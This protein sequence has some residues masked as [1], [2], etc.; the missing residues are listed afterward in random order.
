MGGGR[1]CEPCESRS[2]GRAVAPPGS[3][4]PRN[5]NQPTAPCEADDPQVR[6]VGQIG[7]EQR[8]LCGMALG[9]A[10]LRQHVVDDVKTARPQQRQRLIQELYLPGMASA[11]IRSYDAPACWCRKPAASAV[12]ISSRGSAPRMSRATACDPGS[13]STL[14]S[15][16]SRSMPSSNHA[17]ESPVPVPSSSRRPPGLLAASTRSIAPVLGSDGIGNAN[18]SVRPRTAGSAAGGFR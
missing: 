16:A 13:I 10:G 8:N 17:V 1:W 6:P 7:N 3:V 15:V 11:N 12:T 18:A 4:P 2:P 9:P 5:Q 14:T